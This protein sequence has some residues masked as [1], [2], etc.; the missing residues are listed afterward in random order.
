MARIRPH[1]APPLQ[2]VAISI[3][4]SCTCIQCATSEFFVSVPFEPS[5]TTERSERAVNSHR[6]F[7]SD[8]SG[9]GKPPQGE[10]Y[11][12]IAFRSK[13]S[14]DRYSARRLDGDARGRGDWKSKRTR[15]EG[16]RES[17]GNGGLASQHT[18]EP[19]DQTARP[20]GSPGRPRRPATARHPLNLSS[21]RFRNS[22]TT[23]AANPRSR[24]WTSHKVT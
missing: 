16:Q 18:Q 9:T 10:S 11:K 7:A 12:M 15:L 4:K 19:A 2:T 22:P 1:T 13:K 24:I 5:W 21:T 14:R 8:I 17:R 6:P 3:F 23:T 20:E